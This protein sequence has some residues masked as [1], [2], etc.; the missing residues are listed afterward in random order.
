MKTTHVFHLFCFLIFLSFTTSTT[1]NAQELQQLISSKLEVNHEQDYQMLGSNT[2]R[3]DGE[4]LYQTPN[5]I[6]LFENNAYRFDIGF[7]YFTDKEIINADNYHSRAIGLLAPNTSTAQYRIRDIDP[8][9]GIISVEAIAIGQAGTQDTLTLE[10]WD[11]NSSTLLADLIYPI[12]VH[13]L[14]PS[15][16]TTAY[17]PMEMRY[18]PL[19]VTLEDVNNPNNR[20]ERQLLP[21]FPDT[22]NVDAKDVFNLLT[23]IEQEVY[24]D[25]EAYVL[26]ADH[27]KNYGYRAEF[28]WEGQGLR[29]KPASDNQ[30]KSYLTVV[31]GRDRPS[32]IRPLD[33]EKMMAADLRKAGLNRKGSRIQQQIKFVMPKGEVKKV[34]TAEYL[35]THPGLASSRLDHK[36]LSNLVN[37]NKGQLSKTYTNN[38]N[39]Q[40]IT[41]ARLYDVGRLKLHQPIINQAN[42]SKTKVTPSNT[43]PTRTS[44]R[45]MQMQKAKIVTK[46]TQQQPKKQPAPNYAVTH[47]KVLPAETTPEKNPYYT[48]AIKISRETEPMGYQTY[49]L[50]FRVIE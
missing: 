28:N 29:Y 30:L 18:Q 50:T 24:L 5:T 45:T 8:A 26:V 35:K 49:L 4:M 25:G 1:V 15:A 23:E 48:L 47:I 38:G 2:Y 6:R 42:P 41:A 32:V 39:I 34:Y 46:E 31:P 33:L 12:E 22:I 27:E 7:S 19:F 20:I 17:L 14:D 43:T 37:N 40:L 36:S 16:N 13:T 44:P 10:L 9:D 11:K 3:L 21:F